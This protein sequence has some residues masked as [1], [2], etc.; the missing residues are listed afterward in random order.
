MVSH[1]VYVVFSDSCDV[2]C[3]AIKCTLGTSN[4][5][6]QIFVPQKPASTLFHLQLLMCSFIPFSLASLSNLFPNAPNASPLP[7]GGWWVLHSNHSMYEEIFFF[8]NLVM[9]ILFLVFWSVWKHL[10]LPNWSCYN[11]VLVDHSQLL[12]FLNEELSHVQ[13]FIIEVICLL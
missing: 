3:F 9:A 5:L 8:F 6:V 10:C 1:V 12:I 7:C 4:W 2:G 11:K 13:S